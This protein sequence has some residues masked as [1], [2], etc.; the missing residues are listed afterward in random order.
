MNE[1]LMIRPS[2]GLVVIG[3]NE[4]ERLRRC[5][6]SIPKGIA[7]VYVDSGSTDDSVQFAK[8][9]GVSVIE[10]DT[11]IGFTAARA[12]NAGWTSLV[13][14]VPNLKFI[15]FIDG[16][17]EM[18]TAWLD[19][20]L[21]AMQS[22]PQV[23]A[24]FGRRRERFPDASIYIKICDDE[25]NVPVGL[26][27]SCGGDV[28]FR[29]EALKAVGGYSNDLI[30]GEEPDLCLRLRR[31]GWQILRVDAEMTLHDANILTFSSWWRRAKRGGYAYTQ[32]VVRHGSR[33][34]PHRRQKVAS[35]FFWSIVLPVGVGAIWGGALYFKSL[36]VTVIA[37]LSSSIYAIQVAKCAIRKHS[38]K[39]SLSY[40]IQYSILLLIGKFA[41]LTGLVKCLVDN[42]FNRQQS[43]I[44][45]KGA[46]EAHAEG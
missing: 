20:A 29:T 45:Y 33:S 17:C 2:A 46:G 35:I 8:S 16:D 28:F 40:S 44:E 15:Q 25:W 31:L 19:H 3:R 32:H 4:G 22:N 26:V 38:E 10:L 7:T 34:D 30:A 41:E 39:V 9:R 37:L 12:R 23:A 21:K 11:D 13:N 24:V 42:L 6:R 27:G 36:P 1:T 43:L 18:D 5:L 14:Q